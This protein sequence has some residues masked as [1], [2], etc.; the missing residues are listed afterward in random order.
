M[1]TK[2][3]EHREAESLAPSFGKET[4]LTRKEM[5][6]SPNVVC[7]QPCS[8]LIEAWPSH[9]FELPPALVYPVN[10]GRQ[11][12]FGKQPA[13]LSSPRYQPFLW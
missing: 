2:L 12:T 13:L 9:P 11:W 3:Q 1:L 10:V 4:S 5:N 7:P 6:F 8:V